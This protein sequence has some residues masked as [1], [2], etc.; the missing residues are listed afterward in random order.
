MSLVKMVTGRAALGGTGITSLPFMSSTVKLVRC[1]NVFAV[2]VARAGRA[3]TA[4]Q[5][6]SVRLTLIVVPLSV[7]RTVALTSVMELVTSGSPLEVLCRV[8][9]LGS[10][11]ST[12]TVSSKVRDSL[13]RFRS[14]SKVT[15]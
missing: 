11:V 3:F 15:A 4:F 12:F 13:P 6:L 2:L 8:S 9:S 5:S 1:R 10:K 7:V 14:K